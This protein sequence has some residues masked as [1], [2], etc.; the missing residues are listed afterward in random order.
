MTKKTPE[1]PSDDD[2]YGWMA[3][4]DD[5]GRVV[6]GH[7]SLEQEMWAMAEACF[8]YPDALDAAQLRFPQLV[9]ILMACGL[10]EDFMRPLLALNSVRNAFAHRVGSFFRAQGLGQAMGLVLR[11]TAGDHRRQLS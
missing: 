7:L 2:F 6:R 10:R 9:H 5:V 3:G 8:P 1:S 11:R 4:Q